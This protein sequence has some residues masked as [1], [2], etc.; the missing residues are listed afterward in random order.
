MTNDG[1]S[2]S[3]YHSS[4]LRR[5]DRGGRQR[6][7][8]EEDPDERE[9]HRDLVGDHLRGRPE[10][11]EQRV[12][13]LARPAG[14]H[15]A[16]DADRRHGED[17]QHRDRQV[18]ELQRRVVP[19]IE[20]IGPDRDHREGE[21][22]RGGRDDRRQ[23][24]ERL[25]DHR[26]DQVFLERQLDAVGET[27][28]DTE[29]ADP[30]RARPGLHP[31]DDAALGP[32]HE[33][34]RHD[35]EDEDDDGLEQ[36]SATT[37]RRPK[38]RG[39]SLAANGARHDALPPSGR[40]PYDGRPTRSR[41]TP[42]RVTP[43]SSVGSQ[44]TRSGRSVIASGSVIEPRIGAHGHRLTGSDTER[45]GGRR[46]TAGPRQACGCRPGAARA[47][48]AG[49][50]SSRW[51]QVARTASPAPGDGGGRRRRC[52]AR[53]AARPPR[54]PSRGDLGLGGRAR[55]AYRDRHR[56]RPAS[57]WSTRRSDIAPVDS[58]R[59][60]ERPHPAFPVEVA[61]GL[62][63]D[64]R[65]GQDDVGAV[66]HRRLAELEADHE[67][68]LLQCAQRQCRIS[69]VGRVDAGHDQC[70]ATAGGGRRGSRQ[71]SRPGAAGGQHP[72]RRRPHARA[73]VSA[74]GDRPGSSDGRHPA[75]TA[76]R[77]PARRG[78]QASRAPVTSASV[79]PR[80]SA[81]GA[82]ASR[83]PTRMT[84]PGDR[85]ASRA[86]VAASV[87]SPPDE[88]R[89]ASSSASPPGATCSSRPLEL[90]ATRSVRTARSRTLR[91]GRADCGLAQP[92]EDD[93]RL[94]LGLEADEQDG[95]RVLEIGVR[96]LAGSGRRRDDARNSCSSAE[97]G[98]A[99]KSMSLV[100]SASRA[101]FE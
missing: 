97:C 76:P 36:R 89:A 13:R 101:N 56:A 99:R 19:K 17:E 2:G 64:R 14:Q 29:R 21:E 46:P 74:M 96:R 62:L 43:A 4:L 55:S 41:A 28:H 39:V 40:D 91:C 9:A 22:R 70:E 100:P 68:R 34:R 88:P 23:D 59:R 63:D 69:Q 83:S 78:T 26:R 75:S 50:S 65:D 94:F 67:R 53:P 8:V 31:A 61:A 15:D 37:G 58:K 86:A 6:P 30:V 42:A 18:G 35:Q 45:S 82:D 93:R 90:P 3:A 33:Q 25:V 27:L 71:P 52:W 95:G 81:P 72:T 47:P 79:R 5:D 11:A 1:I 32:D 44:T 73:S 60:V 84:A 85:S 57:A 54:Q 98:R 10:G 49:P 7:G 38:H 24:V 51:C 66:G 20:T 80:V 92:Q 48:G 16:V 77:S 12:R 87:S